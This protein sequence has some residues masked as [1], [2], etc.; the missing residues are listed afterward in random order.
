MRRKAINAKVERIRVVT[1]GMLPNYYRNDNTLAD[2]GMIIVDEVHERS[3]N[4][5]LTLGL[6]KLALAVRSDLRCI[7]MSA[8]AEMDKLEAF[9]KPYSPQLVE[10]PGQPSLISRY[11][12]ERVDKVF[13]NDGGAPMTDIDDE[14]EVCEDGHVQKVDVEITEDWTEAAVQLTNMALTQGSGD[15][16]IFCPGE[17]DISY[18][19]DLLR[20]IPQ[21]S[22]GQVM[23]V[24]LLRDQPSKESAEAIKQ[25]VD[26]EGRVYRKVILST[27][28]GETS[29]TFPSVDTVIDSGITNLSIYDPATRST[30]LLQVPSAR[31]QVS[32]S[33]PPL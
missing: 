2:F 24:R 23:V 32:L 7:C 26:P 18:T 31:D 14:D 20:Q 29:I 4:I 21:I 8:T 30:Q 3:L 17:K 28:V 12:L 27:S 6:I 25:M 19:A 1:D 33:P 9:F 13:D 15:V 22:S 5:D 11:V 10:L 16:L